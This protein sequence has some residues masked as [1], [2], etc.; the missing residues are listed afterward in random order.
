MKNFFILLLAQS[1]TLVVFLLIIAVVGQFYTF[2]KPGYENLDVIPDRQI[3]WRL[4]PNSLFT[5][6]GM[7]WYENEFKN[8]IKTNSLGFRDK[9]RI[10]KKQKDC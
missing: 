10:I 4:V 7:H 1:L 2:L 6:T 5:Y 9:E 3:G 8:Q